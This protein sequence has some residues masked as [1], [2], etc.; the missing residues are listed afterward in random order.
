MYEVIPFLSTSY[1]E[2]E[3]VMQDISPVALLCSAPPRADYTWGQVP[4]SREAKKVYGN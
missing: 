4:L 1:F 3:S 2:M